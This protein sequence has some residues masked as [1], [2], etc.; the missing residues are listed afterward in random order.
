MWSLE[1]GASPDIAHSAAIRRA[2]ELRACAF[3]R[4]FAAMLRPAAAIIGMRS[5]RRDH[6]NP[7]AGSRVTMY[8]PRL[9]A[10]IPEAVSRGDNESLG[11][12]LLK[13]RTTVASLVGTSE[14]HNGL[15]TWT[16]RPRVQS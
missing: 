6:G 9:V 12:A 1:L 8:S 4:A 10:A 13:K 16:D 5:Q 14:M 3:A 2:H 15:A 11:E 7:I